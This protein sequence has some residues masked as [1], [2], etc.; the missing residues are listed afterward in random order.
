MRVLCISNWTIARCGVREYGDQFATALEAAG[1]QVD[2]WDGGYEACYRRGYLPADLSAYDLLHL[3]WDPQTINHYLPQHFAGGPPLSLMLHD[4]PPNSTCPVFDV[5]R[6]RF[7]FE[8]TEGL[9][10]ILPE[11]IPDERPIAPSVSERVVIGVTGIR[12]DP[13]MALVQEV[14]QAEGWD[15]NT[16]VWWVDGADWLP[17]AAEITRLAA[18]TINVCWYHTSGRGKSMAA[19]YCLAAGRPLIL[20]GSSMFSA[21]WPYAREIYI[22]HQTHG[23]LGVTASYTADRLRAQI[24]AVLTDL[25]TGV[26]RRPQ[27]VLIDLAWAQV[28]QSVVRA[29][30]RY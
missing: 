12:S 14:C 1:H 25:R 7:A 8:P 29:W 16:P 2:R 18:S 6:W 30:E 24:H 28:V 17:R 22:D 10:A 26:A 11:A 27:Q 23:R 4:V 13:G 5:A 20:S 21:L 15:C 3:N 19:M 9:D